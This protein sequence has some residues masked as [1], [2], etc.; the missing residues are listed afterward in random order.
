MVINYQ[1]DTEK[2]KNAKL[3]ASSEPGW[4]ITGRYSLILKLRQEN[5]DA[6]TYA[7][8]VN[9]TVNKNIKIYGRLH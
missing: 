8:G 6:K 4:E 9:Y 2:Y 5:Q 1:A 3:G 7:L